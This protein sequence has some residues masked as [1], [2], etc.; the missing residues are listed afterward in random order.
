MIMMK[1]NN[2]NALVKTYGFAHI[3][4][5]E[6]AT[7]EQFESG[8]GDILFKTLV[9]ENP[10]STRSL[11]SN[12]SVDFHT[13]HIK[14]KYILWQCN[15]QSSMG[16]ESLLLDT[17]PYI[18]SVSES[19]KAALSRIAV[20]CHQLFFGD[21][22]Y[23]PLL[24][25]EHI[26]YYAPFLCVLP[27]NKTELLTLAGFQNYILSAPKTE[28]KLSEGDWLIIDNHRMLHARNGFPSGS[29]R[30]LTRY[31]LHSK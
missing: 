5:M 17:R 6:E 13:D 26:L 2:I 20:N 8:F 24:S 3:P 18:T 28:I 16:G 4:L 29:N 25:D 7:L 10:K 23:Y 14:A 11:A 27:G 30:L 19:Q 1:A 22:T 15:S 12:R 21:Q 31:W 9:R